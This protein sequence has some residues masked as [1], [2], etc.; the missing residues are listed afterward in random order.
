MNI[1]N[2]SRANKTEVNDAACSL[3]CF[4]D[5]ALLLFRGR[6]MMVLGRMALIMNNVSGG[7]APTKRNFW[8]TSHYN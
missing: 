7:Y 1:I 2:N 4:L 6:S 8:M 3:H 5:V